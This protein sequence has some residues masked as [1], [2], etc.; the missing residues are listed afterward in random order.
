LAAS[1]EMQV[2]MVQYLLRDKVVGVFCEFFVRRFTYLSL[3]YG[4]VVPETLST[5]DTSPESIITCRCR[6]SVCLTGE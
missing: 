6:R 4:D 1:F 3:L 5:A 2:F